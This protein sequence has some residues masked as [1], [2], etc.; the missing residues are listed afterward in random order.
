[1][2]VSDPTADAMP[3]VAKDLKVDT[4]KGSLVVNVYKN[5]P[6]DKAGLLPGDYVTRVDGQDVKDTNKLIQTVGDLLAGRSYDFDLVRGGEKM[7]LS[8]KLGVRPA[9]GSD[10]L[11]TRTLWPGL[12]VVHINEQVRQ[13][14]SQAGDDSIPKGVDGMMV[15]L[16]NTPGTDPT[17]AATA[18]LKI[19]DVI[20]QVNGKDVKNAMDLYKGLNDRSRSTITIKVSRD[21]TDVTMTLPR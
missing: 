18:G 19:G 13:A 21:G 9:D 17:P 8:V 15:A 1:V 16:L 6:A 5:S 10:A 3:G 11:S 12:T 4:L 20:T 7:S 2:T 14:F